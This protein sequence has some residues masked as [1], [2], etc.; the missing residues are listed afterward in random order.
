MPD[1]VVSACNA[2]DGVRVIWI[3][4]YAAGGNLFLDLEVVEELT[5]DP[6]RG[7][8]PADRP[9]AGGLPR[10]LGDAGPPSK[11]VVAARP[12]R[13]PSELPFVEIERA[14][15]ARGRRRRREHLRRRPHRR[16][17]RSWSSAAAVARS[18]STPSS[19]ASATWSAWLPRSRCGRRRHRG[20]ADRL[21]QEDRDLPVGPLLVVRVRRVLRHAALPPLGALVALG[22]AGDVLVRLGAVLEVDAAGRRGSCGTRSGASARRPARRR[23][24]RRRPSRPASPGS[25]G[26]CRSSAPT[27]VITTIGHSG[28]PRRMLASRAAGPLVGLDLVADP[29]GRAGLVLALKCHIHP[30]PATGGRAFLVDSGARRGSG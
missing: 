9:A 20:S 19:P 14:A 17:R 10:R 1:S 21:E 29:L 3:S 13:R 22:D 18:S 5:A 28:W 7:A 2:L 8:R 11:G 25:C 30:E 24:R 27:E 4:R 23:R 26:A 12:T 6:E 15:A 16:Q